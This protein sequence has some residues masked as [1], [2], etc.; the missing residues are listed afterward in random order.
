VIEAERVIVALDMLDEGRALDLADRLRPAGIQW[1]KV[2][3][4]LWVHAGRSVV[5]ALKARG[6]NVFLDLKLHDIPHQVGLATEAA[7]N[8]GVDLLT[9]HAAGGEAMMR[10]AVA[11]RSG[12][13]RILAITVLTSLETDPAVVSD[14]ALRARES[15]VDGVV[16]SPLEVGALRDR[17]APPFLLVTPGVRPTGSV[18]GDQKRVATPE[19]ALASGSDLLVIGRPITQ[20]LDPVAAARQIIAG[21]VG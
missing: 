9:I 5:D 20:A 18:V 3:L 1:F 7:S 13:T 6:V 8:L 19:Q 15:G 12:A 17:H 11:S 21:T 10:A 14:R 2:G 4:S 16:C